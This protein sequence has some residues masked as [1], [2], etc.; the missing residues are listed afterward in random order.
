MRLI[1]RYGSGISRILDAC[2]EGSLPA[3]LFENFSGGFR[4]KFML[5]AKVTGEVSG[6]GGVNG[7]VNGGVDQLMSYITKYPGKRA[8]ELAEACATPKRTIERRLKKLKDEGLVEFRGAPKTG[9]Y[10]PTDR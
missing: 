9:G 4:I 10:H 8:A 5:P 3:P 6:D 2:R 7:G 1:E